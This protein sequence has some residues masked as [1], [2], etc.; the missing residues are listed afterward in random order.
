MSDDSAAPA[1]SP[2]EDDFIPV[3]LL[4]VGVPPKELSA[5][6]RHGKR[7]QHISAISGPVKEAFMWQAKNS[8]HG[9]PLQGLLAAEWKIIWPRTRRGRYDID[10][11]ASL[12]KPI[13]DSLQGVVYTNDSQIRRATYEQV[14]DQ[15]GT[16]DDGGVSLTVWRYH[17]E[18]V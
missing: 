13:Q 11:L 5:N 2:L 1:P 18:D 12:L 4:F 8:Y 14:K 15:T 10:S 6:N 7:G 3:L 16:W 17:G 9:A